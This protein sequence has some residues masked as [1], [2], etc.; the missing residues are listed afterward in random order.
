[1][2]G[3][4]FEKYL[5]Q[6]FLVLLLCNGKQ[7]RVMAT[8]KKTD[9]A[10]RRSL[11]ATRRTATKKAAGRKAALRKKATAKKQAGRPRKPK[12]E[13][14][15]KRSK[16]DSTDETFEVVL[17]TA[18][19]IVIPSPLRTALGVD[20]GDVLRVRVRAGRLIAST[21]SSDVEYVQEL[22][23]QHVDSR[24]L[25]GIKKTRHGR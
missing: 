16:S 9:K 21:P 15:T 11:P 7:L 25:T 24:S 17:G 5:I 12:P 20:E 19:R 6:T 13:P 4:I 1:M 3:R 10:Q 22:L 8:K 18:G 14:T 23:G 2:N